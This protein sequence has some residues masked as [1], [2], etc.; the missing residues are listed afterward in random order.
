M[1]TIFYFTGTGNSF[2]IAR[3]VGEK[4]NAKL[5]SIVDAMEEERE[6]KDDIIGIVV[7]IYCMDIPKIAKKF[8]EKCKISKESYIFTVVTCAGAEGRAFYN[9]KEILD[10]RGLK[11][12]YGY[13]CILPDNSI[14]FPTN[15]EKKNKMFN[16][17]EE[18]IRQIVLDVDKRSINSD[19][20]KK[21]VKNDITK[22][23]L[24]E[25]LNLIYKINNKTIDS[26]KCIQC[27]VCE[28]VCPVSNIHRSE[29]KYVIG[30]N[31]ENCFAC[32]QWCPKRALAIG[33][34]TPNDKTHYTHPEVTV[35][36]IINQKSKNIS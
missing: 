11:L 19:R 1:A 4:L 5:V 20:F 28:K 31:C 12:S 13:K 25:G 2:S 23:V 18:Y 15:E 26:Q 10:K 30:T 9:V 14:V 17:Q 34:L 33:K 36:D 3:A 21:S 22:K 8:L 24:E 29:D 6:F 35:K 7:P 16:D 27:G 32:A